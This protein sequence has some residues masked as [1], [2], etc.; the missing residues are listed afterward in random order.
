MKQPTVTD[1][2][3]RS[4]SEVADLLRERAISSTELTRLMLD[5]IERLNP[6]LNAFITVLGEEAM[7]Q[8]AATDALLASGTRLGPLHGVPVAVKDNMA[9]AGARTT[10]AS[11][12]LK[13]WVPDR[14]ATVVSR[15]KRAG[16]VILGKL[17]MY[18]FAFGGVNE[19]YGECLNPWDRTRCCSSS[20]SGPGCAVAAGMAY[21]G[22]GT[23]TGGSIRLPAAACGVVGLKPTY[24]LVSRAGVVPA[25]YS[26]DHVGPL[27]RTVRDVAVQMSVVAG[28]DSDDPTS[29]RAAAADFEAGLE[30]GLSGIV[31]GVPK[32]QRTEVIDEEMLHAYLAALTTM[33]NEGAILQE[34]D[35]PDHLLSGT[36]IWGISAP[37][38]A[39]AHREWTRSRPDDYSPALRSVVQLGE[40]LPATE[41]VHAH[42]VRQVI[43]SAYAEVMRH[44]DVLAMPVVPFPAWEV[45]AQTITIGSHD[46]Q[47][48]MTAL[49]RY[50]S[51]ANITGQPAVSVPCGFNR[52]GLP[53]AFQLIGSWLEDATLLRVARAYE[54]ATE[55]H[56]HRPQLR[57]D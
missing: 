24:G 22:L 4:L 33:Q 27:G 14:D 48:L 12:V 43:R 23:D 31:V 46:A 42:R 11:R 51:P 20:S 50:C 55:W 26:L 29:V 18:E 45:G 34:V 6:Q 41:Y 16:A 39:E 38:V 2:L 35:V 5:R 44:V 21:G 8:A 7:Q 56:T 9:T 57:G 40:F 13:D 15:L 28:H 10:A 36:V 47:D 25:S 53:L 32:S 49:T 1:L 17:N 54:R 30:A 37:E 52:G 3:Y 19:D